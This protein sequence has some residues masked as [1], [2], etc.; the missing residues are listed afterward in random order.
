M[1]LLNIYNA[2]IFTNTMETKNVSFFLNTYVVSLG[3][4]INNLLFQYGN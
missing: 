2:D 4:I 3:T 1:E